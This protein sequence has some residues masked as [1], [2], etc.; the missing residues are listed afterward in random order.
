MCVDASRTSIPRKG[1]TFYV[2]EALE[3]FFSANERP[4]VADLK[5]TTSEQVEEDLGTR[6]LQAVEY[7]ESGDYDP[8]SVFDTF[9]DFVAWAEA[10]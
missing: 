7:L 9:E 5:A 10:L 2:F 6:T 1:P 8:D 3:S 4:L